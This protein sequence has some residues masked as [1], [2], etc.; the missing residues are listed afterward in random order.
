MMEQQQAEQQ[1]ADMFKRQ[2]MADGLKVAIQQG[3]W[4]AVEAA[5]GD[6]KFIGKDFG[7][8]LGMLARSQRSRIDESAAASERN[9][10]PQPGA[11]A[12][13]TMQAPPRATTAMLPPA[14]GSVTPQ[15]DPRYTVPGGMDVSRP[16]LGA[17]VPPAT[18][19]P[20]VGT[21]GNAAIGR[22]SGVQTQ[23][24]P[25]PPPP[26]QQ[27]DEVAEVMAGQY[28][29]M[30]VPFGAPGGAYYN[31]GRAPAAQAPPVSTGTAQAAPTDATGAA[32]R[33]LEDIDVSRPG[34]FKQARQFVDPL[35]K[36]LVK[37][38]PPKPDELFR[39]LLQGAAE[40][41]LQYEPD[42]LLAE[43]VRRGWI[44][45]IKAET[46]DRIG[47]LGYNRA[48]Q[49]ETTALG[50]RS[51]E[52]LDPNERRLVFERAWQRSGV[53]TEAGLK[54]IYPDE[55][56]RNEKKLQAYAIQRRE[57]PDQSFSQAIATLRARGIVL[58]KDEEI[59]F[60]QEEFARVRAG[61]M[62]QWN[63]TNPAKPIT[64]EQAGAL[65]IKGWFGGDTRYAPEHDRAAMKKELELDLTKPGGQMTAGGQRPP[66]AEDIT[67]NLPDIVRAQQAAQAAAATQVGAEAEARKRGEGRAPE[68]A[69][70]GAQE[71]ARREHLLNIKWARIEAMEAAT[72][73]KDT[74][75]PLG[76]RG[77]ISTGRAAMDDPKS[78]AFADRVAEYDAL[79]AQ[80]AAILTGMAVPQHE[81]TLFLGNFPDPRKASGVNL[82]AQKK[83]TKNH[84]ADLLEA[85]RRIEG[86][87]NI[88]PTTPG[89]GSVPPPIGSGGALQGIPAP[90][91]KK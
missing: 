73:T 46:L 7:N 89:G 8:W 12:A 61:V 32:R 33:P 40:K 88:M 41:R 28:Y 30:G 23:F 22:F 26:I 16:P 3:N 34:D 75:G 79:K 84:F 51:I 2:M 57:K 29:K 81:I 17:D 43:V 31:A 74:G 82:A 85:R 63:T 38:E 27:R 67:P 62:K 37:E 87:Q 5:A 36:H 78:Q 15:P 71:D 59:R 80:Y 42:D 86:S 44:N 68:R 76:V 9:T 55:G 18:S 10:V 21:S 49:R 50:A 72:T 83:A 90:P 11:M 20:P 70:A 53:V 48:V 77:R 45:D 14:G 56:A 19:P 35:T 25:P 66:R 64:E 39:R 65:A 91:M 69:P 47:R 54:E 58:P 52:E 60:G 6:T 13:S 1:Q 24:A 4:E